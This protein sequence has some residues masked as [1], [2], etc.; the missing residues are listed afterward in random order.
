[1]RTRAELTNQNFVPPVPL[2]GKFVRKILKIELFQKKKIQLGNDK[3]SFIWI[4]Y[5][6]VSVET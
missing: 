3:E 2:A 6:V 5:S 4:F 1:M